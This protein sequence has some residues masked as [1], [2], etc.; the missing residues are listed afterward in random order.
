MIRGP[1]VDEDDKVHDRVRA[2]R[3]RA[4][5]A[6][7]ILPSLPDCLPAD[8]PPGRASTLHSP[9]PRLTRC[10]PRHSRTLFPRTVAPAIIDPAINP[11]PVLLHHRFRVGLHLGRGRRCHSCLSLL[12]YHFNARR[13]RATPDR[14]P[15]GLLGS[16][17]S[18]K[19]IRVVPQPRHSP[20]TCLGQAWHAPTEDTTNWDPSKLRLRV[21]IAPTTGQP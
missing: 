10:Q 1:N 12:R 16:G 18:Q 8:P 9:R 17:A 15:R 21:L 14:C 11:A 2:V 7:S 4:S 13:R 5:R 6:Q 19:R 20:W 3:Q